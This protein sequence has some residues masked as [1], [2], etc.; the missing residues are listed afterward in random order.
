[1]RMLTAMMSPTE[2]KV[3]GMTAV[4]EVSCKEIGED[5]R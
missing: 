4:H 2:P 1:M 3:I 5:R